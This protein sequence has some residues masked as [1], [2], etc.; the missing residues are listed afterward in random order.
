LPFRVLITL[1]GALL[2]AACQSAPPS[3]RTLQIP[4]L[5]VAEARA[6]E[7]PRYAGIVVDTASGDVLYAEDADSPRHPASLAKLM[8]LYLLFGALHDGT[9]TMASAIP[10][11][12]HAAAQPASK[13][14]LKAG[15]T[16][17]VQD[18][19][20]AIC[21]RSA[22]D[23]AVAVGEELAGSEPAFAEEMTRKGRELGLT[24]TRFTNATG[25]P[26]D[27]TVTTARDIAKLARAVQVDFPERYSFFSTRTFTYAGRTLNS[28]NQL[29]GA[30]PGVDGMKTGYIN[31]SGYNLV[32]SARRNG[33]RI[34]VVVMGEKTGAARNGHVAALIEEYLPQNSGLFAAR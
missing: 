33:K 25:L 32:A 28:T 14:G 34:L 12:A 26:D 16:I 20:L 6:I 3:S 23:V 22:N 5:A 2:L 9:L 29:L 4:S 19:I 31:A 15:G 24:S 8:T 11:S 10:V 1:L 13:L 27:R 18:A 17:S 7:D 21:V 30:I